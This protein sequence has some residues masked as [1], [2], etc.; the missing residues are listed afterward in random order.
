MSGSREGTPLRLGGRRT[1]PVKRTSVPSL[2]QP[3]ALTPPTQSPGTGFGNCIFCGR[4]MRVTPPLPRWWSD[5]SVGGLELQCATVMAT[6][7]L[8]LKIWMFCALIP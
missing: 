8:G 7:E 6:L 5:L 3:P 4:V 2:P 1:D